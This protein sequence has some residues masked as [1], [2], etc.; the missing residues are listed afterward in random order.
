MGLHRKSRATACVA[1]LAFV[2]LATG[3]LSATADA[4]SELQSLVGIR[5]WHHTPTGCMQCQPFTITPKIISVSPDGKMK[6]RYQTPR[7]P[8]GV[9][10]R[11]R[12]T[13]AGGK[14][15]LALQA[16]GISYDPDYLKDI[17]SLRG[18]VVGFPTAA[19]VQGATFL[20]EK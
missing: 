2:V 12:A 1:A 8:N 19:H 10:V 20:R 13:L 18:P 6:A 7:A 16:T 14:I 17:D 15:K 4:R 9:P 3:A 11:P 5:V